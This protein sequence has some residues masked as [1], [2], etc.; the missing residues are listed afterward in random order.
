MK[1][2]N[3]IITLIRRPPASI[4]LKIVVAPP[5]EEREEKIR[6]YYHRALCKAARQKCAS[7]VF[8]I[9]DDGVSADALSI[10]AKIMAQEIFR[11]LHEDA[12]ALKKIVVSASS[13]NAYA[14]CKKNTLGYL[15]YIEYKLK[16][17][18]LTVDAIIEYKGGIILI[19]RSNPPLGW[20]MPGGFV[21]Y[22]ES[23]E[24]AVIREAKEET[25][26]DIYDLKQLH[27][28]SDPR[29][30]PRF[31][32]VCTVF[33]ANGKGTPRAGDDAAGIR[34]VSPKELKTIYFAFHHGLVLE[35]YLKF[36]AGKYPY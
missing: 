26:L 23:L 35:D 1:I 9:S 32:T 18:F 34:V 33:I 12:H 5:G 19:K 24:D 14:A 6:A 13:K 10:T 31:H 11:L 30:D 3:T 17:P 22:G 25:N 8:S 7:I 27:T 16:S 28:Y 29:R 2:K 15:D 4:G 21:D 36:K 20:A